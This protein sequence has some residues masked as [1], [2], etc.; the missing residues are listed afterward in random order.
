MF[1]CNVG[2][3]GKLC[4]S[5]REQERQRFGALLINTIS[6]RLCKLYICKILFKKIGST[7]FELKY[8]PGSVLLPGNPLHTEHRE[9]ATGRIYSLVCFIRIIIVIFS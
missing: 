9:K 6:H 3:R 4:I 2:R 1:V 7:I 8:K 5:K